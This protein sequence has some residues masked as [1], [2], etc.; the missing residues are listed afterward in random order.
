MQQQ[1]K[2]KSM[3]K[4]VNVCKSMKTYEKVCKSIQKNSK[5][6]ERVQKYANVFKSMLML[7]LLYVSNQVFSRSLINRPGVAAAVLQTPA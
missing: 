5:E 2:C 1:Q 7:F 6:C 3:Q 4:D